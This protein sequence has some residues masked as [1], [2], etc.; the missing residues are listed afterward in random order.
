MRSGLRYAEVFRPCAA[1]PTPQSPHGTPAVAGSASGP[2]RERNGYYIYGYGMHVLSIPSVRVWLLFDLYPIVNSKP[3]FTL[4]IIRSGSIFNCV[5][6]IEIISNHISFTSTFCIQWTRSRR[7]LDSPDESTRRS[8]CRSLVTC[9]T[10]TAHST[11][12]FLQVAAEAEQQCPLLLFAHT[13][14]L[15]VLSVRGLLRRKDLVVGCADAGGS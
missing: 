7:T 11:W 2:K 9:N 1:T 3:Y 4:Y 15:A 12:R 8:R 6:A 10:H 5:V 13:E 14:G